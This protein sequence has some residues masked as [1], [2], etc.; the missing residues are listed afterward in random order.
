MTERKIGFQLNPHLACL[1]IGK[2]PL[3]ALFALKVFFGHRRTGDGDQQ[4]A[5]RI[6]RGEDI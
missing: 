5:A 1:L 4:I 3:D 2:E 6:S